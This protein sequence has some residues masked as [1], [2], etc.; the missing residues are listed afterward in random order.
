M[1]T[2]LTPDRDPLSRRAWLRAGA[3]GLGGLALPQLAAARPAGR[4][5]SVIVFG[6]LGGPSQHDTWDP[7]PDAPAEVRGPFGSIATRTPGLRVGELMP[8]TAQLTDKLAVLRAVA[9]DDNAHS[10][11]GY[12]M[13]TGVPHQPPSQENATPR[14]PNNAPSLGSIV[15]YLRPAPGKLPA[16]VTLPEHMWNDGG[17]TWPGQDAGLLGRKHDPWLVP[18]DPSNARFKIDSLAAPDEVPAAR[19]R[20]RRG[21]L[22]GL[23]RFPTGAESESY[24][25]GVR[26]AFELVASGAAREAF[27]L[28]REPAK[29]RERYGNSRFAQSC[30]LARRLVEAGVSLVQVNWTRIANLP[31]QGGWDTHAKHNDAAKDFLM[32]MMDRAFSALVSDLEVRGLLDET[33][34]VWFGEF[35]RTPRFNGNAGRDHWGH[36]FSLALAGGGVRGGVVY[37][38]S[39]KHGARP[40]DGRVAPR[41]LIATVLHLLGLPPEAELR[42][43]EGRPFPASRGEV[44][45]AV[46]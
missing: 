45:R 41:D 1:L 42:D 33:L 40:A 21:L 3:V 27:D 37:G 10:S 31:N 35:G 44:I 34:V 11:S 43:T 2:L 18:C 25:A 26:K 32:P 36:V 38:A 28:N 46:V 16:A 8:L 12:Q 29:L 6:L 30:L 24:D 39:D 15:R 14:A 7:K 9:T 5:K 17:F 22:G 20:D 19:L 13:L 4:A 23:D